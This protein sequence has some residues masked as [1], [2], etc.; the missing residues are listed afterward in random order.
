[1]GCR[2]RPGQVPARRRKA[3]PPSATR[4]D[5]RREAVPASTARALFSAER[6]DDGLSFVWPETRLP[7][8]RFSVSGRA[9][10]GRLPSGQVLGIGATYA[11]ARRELFV[12]AV[13]CT[14][15]AATCFASRPEVGRTP[16]PATTSR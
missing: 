15:P 6:T 1:V 10:Y 12:V 8:T 16:G 7:G 11:A 4:Q 3:R 13:N 9:T 14:E 2:D 5:R